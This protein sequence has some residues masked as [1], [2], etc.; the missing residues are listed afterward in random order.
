MA[1]HWYEG[2]GFV[3]DRLMEGDHPSAVCHPDRHN[4]LTGWHPDQAAAA[5]DPLGHIQP[6]ATG[7]PG[8]RY[9]VTQEFAGLGSRPEWGNVPAERKK[10]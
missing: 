9:N 10:A 3:D 5:C 1:A 6:I 8:R 7:R 4:K 2:Y